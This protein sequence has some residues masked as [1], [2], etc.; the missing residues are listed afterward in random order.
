MSSQVGALIDR[1]YAR[2]DHAVANADGECTCF[3]FPLHCSPPLNQR[4]S[5]LAM[6]LLLK[7]DLAMADGSSDAIRLYAM[8][9]QDTF[10]S[11]SQSAQRRATASKDFH[12]LSVL[13]LLGKPDCSTLDEANGFAP[14]QGFESCA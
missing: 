2:L 4:F 8:M 5:S 11:C 12:E 13:H 3:P 9:D 6:A 14:A 10:K 7:L 1:Y